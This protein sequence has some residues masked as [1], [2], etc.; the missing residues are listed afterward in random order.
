MQVIQFDYLLITF[1]IF[2]TVNNFQTYKPDKVDLTVV[3]NTD[4]C[5]F[6]NP[7]SHGLR[8]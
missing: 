4:Y 8:L 1:L 7:S 2:S 5:H 3:L 6:R